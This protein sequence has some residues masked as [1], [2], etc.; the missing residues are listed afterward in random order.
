MAVLG[1]WQKAN[2]YFK[3]PIICNSSSIE[4]RLK[5]EWEK[6]KLSAGNKLTK[7]HKAELE[8]R[9]ELTACWILFTA[10]VSPSCSVRRLVARVPRVS[11]PAGWEPTRP[12][13]PALGR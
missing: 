3:P 12:P 8:T 13:A 2:P 4:R 11:L 1:Q 5:V 6:A 9:L 10:P 7:K